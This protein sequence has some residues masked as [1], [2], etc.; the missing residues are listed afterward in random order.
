MLLLPT[1]SVARRADIKR[2]IL[3]GTI[4]CWKTY[5]SI[6]ECGEMT[7]SVFE[8]RL[9]N[10]RKWQWRTSSRRKWPDPERGQ[11]TVFYITRQA[12]GVACEWFLTLLAEHA[13]S[14]YGTRDMSYAKCRRRLCKDGCVNSEA[15]PM[16]KGRSH[17]S[18]IHLPCR[19]GSHDRCRDLDE[20]GS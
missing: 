5:V 15:S 9:P 19:R 8:V 20:T 4:Q 18:P 11:G 1:S 13:L 6:R 3:D 17:P 14:D 12:Y 16:R 2:R 10:H 7:S